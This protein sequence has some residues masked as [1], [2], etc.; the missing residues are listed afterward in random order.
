[1]FKKTLAVLFL[2]LLLTAADIY[3]AGDSTMSQYSAKRYPQAGWGMALPEFCRP[4][5]TVINRATGGRSSMSFISEKRW[6]GILRAG[7]SGDFV[8]IQF[9]HNDAEYGEKNIYRTTYPETTFPLYLKIYIAEARRRGMIPVLCTQTAVHRFNDKGRAFNTPRAETYIAACR[10]VA[11]ETGCDFVDLNAA[12]LAAMNEMGR[13]ASQ[14]NHL[15]LPEGKYPNFF[16]GI[17]DN[18]HLSSKGAK[19]YAELFVK[20]AKRQKLPVAGLFL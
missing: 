11:A 14:E 3:M 16:D 19:F 10:K 7:K 15:I 9:G 12:A 13:S 2:P 6:E 17:N 20:E 18:V 1:M 8:I 4:G 5:V